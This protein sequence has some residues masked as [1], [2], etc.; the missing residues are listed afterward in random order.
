MWSNLLQARFV[1][2]KRCE[3]I[4]EALMECWVSRNGVFD[5]TLRQQRRVLWVRV[6]QDD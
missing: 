6:A 5:S 1:R 4:M 2:S 3:D